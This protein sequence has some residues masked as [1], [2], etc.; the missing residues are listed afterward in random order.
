VSSAPEPPPLAERIARG[1]RGAVIASIALLAGLAWA[2]TTLGAG[3]HGGTG[4]AGMAPAAPP[5]LL[6]VLTMWWVMMAAMMLPSAA[7]AILLYGRVRLMHRGGRAVARSW[8]FMGGYLLAW[9]GIAVLAT[10]LQSLATKA[11]LLDAMTM[12]ATSPELAGATLLAAGLYQLSSV[13]DACLV[14]CRSPAAFLS[15]HWRGQA[16]GALRLGLLHGSY[17]VGCCW[18]LMALLFV[19]GIMNF[20]WIAAL[21]ALVAVE[22]LVRRG[23]QIGK[24]AGVVLI[25]WGIVRIAGL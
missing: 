17:C 5:G 8:I 13:K 18:L 7:P 6:L 23:P 19:G 25:L 20:L 12:R 21:S 22:K 11:G 16:S 2:W 14:N 15:R 9:L 24:A 4:M 1:E 10:A 3:L